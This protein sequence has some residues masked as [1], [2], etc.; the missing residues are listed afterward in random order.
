[1]WLALQGTWAPLN[2]ICAMANYLNQ[3]GQRFKKV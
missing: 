2:Y 1:L 3:Y